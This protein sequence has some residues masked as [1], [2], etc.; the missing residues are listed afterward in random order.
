MGARLLAPAVRQFD[1]EGQLNDESVDGWI[2]VQCLH[3][4][5]ELFFEDVLRKFHQA[6]YQNQRV[7]T[8]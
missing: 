4:V 6:C 5:Q 2:F 1:R 7:R 3:F 8:L